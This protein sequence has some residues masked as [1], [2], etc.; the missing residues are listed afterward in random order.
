MS[1]H[2]IRPRP[3]GSKRG[4][5]E[6]GRIEKHTKHE[7]HRTYLAV[8]N[9]VAKNGYRPDL[10]ETAVQRASAI[11]HSQR[12]TKAAPEKKLR[13]NKAKKAAAAQEA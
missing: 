3:R 4:R 10:R 11:R 5:G 2:E 13:G 6:K 9:K 7:A 8:A 12:P 1:S